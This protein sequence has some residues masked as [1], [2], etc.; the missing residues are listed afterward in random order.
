LISVHQ[1]HRAAA[2]ASDTVRQSLLVDMQ[3]SET[4]QRAPSAV[5][6]FRAATSPWQGGRLDVSVF[7][8]GFRTGRFA[9]LRLS[10]RS[11]RLAVNPTET[12][13][14][15]APNAFSFE[16]TGL[17]AERDSVSVEIT[18]LEP[19]INYVWRVIQQ[20]S[21]TVI[22]SGVTRAQALACP[23][24]TPVIDTSAIKRH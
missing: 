9:S 8:D 10:A 7:K 20:R 15:L 4:E 22:Q 1:M 14:R 12:L 13:R 24:D 5:I 18:P 3:C 16:M 23:S 19:G 2:S 6:R 11:E 21:G 17:R